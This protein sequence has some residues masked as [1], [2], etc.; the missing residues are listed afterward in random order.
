MPR[1][2][3]KKAPK[4]KPVPQVEPIEGE[5]FRFH[6]LSIS[7]PNFPH[8]VDLENYQ[9]NGECDCEAFGFRHA[10]KLSRGA[11]PSDGKRCSHIKACR[12]YFL[13]QILPKIADSIKAN[14]EQAKPNP[15]LVAHEIKKMLHYL[16]TTPGSAGQKLNQLM[17]V[18]VKLDEAINEL[19]DQFNEQ[20]S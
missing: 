9:W 4:V 11:G 15:M 6:A 10:P 17:G 13:D 2:R 12:S 16:K 19:S 7:K 3:Q 5:M 8:L 18:R 1:P 20:P 14:V